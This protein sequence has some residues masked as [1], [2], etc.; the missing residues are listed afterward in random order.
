MFFNSSNS[1][2]ASLAPPSST[3]CLRYPFVTWIL[4]SFCVTNILLLLPLCL[5]IFVLALRRWRSGSRTS[6][7][8]SDLFTYH[9]AA[10]E[11]T[12]VLGCGCFCCGVL[13]QVRWLVQMGLYGIIL[14]SQAQ[15]FFHILSTVE[16][17]L[18]VVHPITYLHVWK[19]GGARFQNLTIACTWLLVLGLV[20]LDLLAFSNNMVTNLCVALVSMLV[21]S[22]CSVSVLRSLIGPGPGDGAKDKAGGNQMKMRAFHTIVAILGA[23]LFRFCGHLFV[24]VVYTMT[25]WSDAVRCGVLVSGVWYSLPSSLVLPL[26]FLHRAGK[27][28]CCRH[29]DESTQGDVQT[30]TSSE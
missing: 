3:S 6:T 24:L 11:M 29:N 26:L 7:S 13:V 4:F 12:G 20:L 14:A 22:F 30:K 18:A 17:Y 28:P 10:M 16:R 23:L 21:V 27:L 15:I 9:L 25:K 8:H 1:S 19:R 2:N 5:F